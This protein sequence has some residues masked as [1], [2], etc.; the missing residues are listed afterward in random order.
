M[1]QEKEIRQL[2][3]KYHYQP[4][5]TLIFIG[6]VFISFIYNLLQI[7]FRFLQYLPPSKEG[8]L[9]TCRTFIMACPALGICTSTLGNHPH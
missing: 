9:Y 8:H 2:F 5:K 1:V 4:T 3:K 6:F 7:S